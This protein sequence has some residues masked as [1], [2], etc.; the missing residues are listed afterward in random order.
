MTVFKPRPPSPKLALSSPDDA[1]LGVPGNRLVFSTVRAAATP[2]K[3]FTFTNTGTRT[4]DRAAGWPLEGADASSFAF[5]PGQATTLVI[6]PGGSATVSILF[7]PTATTN[8]P[9][10]TTYP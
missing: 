4:R 10:G 6:P 5:A 8:C 9:S 1:T 7:R 2:A 3:T